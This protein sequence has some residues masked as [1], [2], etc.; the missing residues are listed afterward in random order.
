VSKIQSILTARAGGTKD[1]DRLQLSIAI[2]AAAEARKAVDNAAAARG[3]ALR[4]VDEAEA[5]LVSASAAVTEAKDS[6]ARRMTSYAT[7]GTALA[8]DSLLRNCRVEER[9]AEDSLDAARAALAA[10]EA[11]IEGSIEA[12]RHADRRVG[13]LQRVILGRNIEPAIA[14][15]VRAKAALVDA[16]GVLHLLQA[17]CVESYPP[18][19][20]WSR[21]RGHVV[22]E[23][24]GGVCY[25]LDHSNSRAAE[26]WAKYAEELKI[27][28]DAAPP[29]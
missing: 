6:L 22:I 4:M 10:V 19:S 7:E 25:E 16:I 17:A 11:T 24:R 26:R 23:V 21:L 15:V 1:G 20:E 18:N 12:L 28:A 8:P 3:R 5:R 27:S 29:T 9:D 2:S 13:E 14:D